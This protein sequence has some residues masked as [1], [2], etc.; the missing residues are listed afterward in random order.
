MKRKQNYSNH[1]PFHPAYHLFILPAS[2]IFF[3]LSVY[4]FISKGILNQ[5]WLEATYFLMAGTIVLTGIWLI[6]AYAIVLQHR[7]IRQEMRLRYFIVSGKPFNEVENKLSS[8]QISA[9]R[10]A[11]DSELIYL[12]DVTL[13]EKLSP[14]DI[15]KKIRQWKGDYYQV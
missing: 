9:L 3:G 2:F 4:F 14:A 11:S 6:R 5:L 8:R 7:I 13:H 15:K 10:F 12:I 1:N